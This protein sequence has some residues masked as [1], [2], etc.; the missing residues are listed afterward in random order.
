M[1]QGIRKLNYG[2]TLSEVG[3]EPILTDK[4][5]APKELLNVINCGCKT[6]CSTARCGCSKL[7]FMCSDFCGCSSENCQNRQLDKDGNYS[8]EEDESDVDEDVDI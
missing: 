1:K 8:D 6:D 7:Q 3:Y 4:D 2:W 5:I